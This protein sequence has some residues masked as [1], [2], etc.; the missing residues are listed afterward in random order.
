VDWANP[1]RTCWWTSRTVNG[2]I[3]RKTFIIYRAQTVVW[4]AVFLMI[5]RG[6]LP[7]CGVFL[8]GGSCLK[9][10]GTAS[11]RIMN[12]LQKYPALVVNSAI[13]WR[14]STARRPWSVNHC[15]RSVRTWLAAVW[16]WLAELRF[17]RGVWK[18]WV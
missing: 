13:T 6:F 17:R 2:A 1:H 14:R 7:L 11:R 9:V 16:G 3:T 4:G 12:I 8:S 5:E 10:F 15:A 18:D